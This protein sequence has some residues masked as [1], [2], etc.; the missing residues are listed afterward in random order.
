MTG[1]EEQEKPPPGLHD[2]QVRSTAFGFLAVC[3]CGEWEGWFSGPRSQ[4]V[5]LDDHDH[6]RR[7]ASNGANTPPLE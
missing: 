2:L 5:I 3:R 6:H 4:A 1:T 7:A